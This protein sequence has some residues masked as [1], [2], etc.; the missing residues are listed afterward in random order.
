MEAA[1][2]TAMITPTIKPV[3]APA[4]NAKLVRGQRGVIALTVVAGIS[5]R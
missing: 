5:A 4:P 1:T 2:I 3:L